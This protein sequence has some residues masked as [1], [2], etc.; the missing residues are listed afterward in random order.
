MIDFDRAIQ[1]A[2]ANVE[3]LVPNAKNITLEGVLIS[4]DNKLYEVTF[5]Y[6]I[7]RLPGLSIGAA[8]AVTSNIE[9]LTRLVGKRREYKVFLVDSESGQ[10]RGFKKY[11]E[12]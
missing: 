11:K 7:E 4:S 2:W 5:S 9:M 1:V 8:S 6:D 3:K 10:F 12:D